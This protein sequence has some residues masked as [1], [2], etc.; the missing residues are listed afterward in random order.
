M[1]TIKDVARDAGVSVGTVSNVLNGGRVSEARRK[2]VEASIEKLGYQ[3]NTL[4]KG[5]RMQK[6]D[7]VVVI[8]PNLI[9]PYF[10]LLLD[11]LES[12][13]SA[14]G[15]QVLL[16]LSGDDAEREVAFMDMAKQNKVDGII[17][18]TYSKVEEERIEN[19]AFVSID[20]HYKSHIPCVAGDNWQG[21]W[22]A[23]ENLHKRGSTN[24][25]CFMTM[26]SVDSEVRKRRVG[27]TEYCME[28]DLSC[29]SVEMSEKQIVSVYES[30]GSR[31]LI[32]NM[33]RAYISPSMGEHSMGEHSI[34]GIF[35][36]S[37]HLA[38]IVREELEE[39]G[40]RV[41]EDIQIIGY[42]GLQFLN[43]GKPIVSSIAQPLHEIA[44]QA[45]KSLTD[46]IE[47]G[48]AEDV[49]NIPVTFHEGS[50]T[51]PLETISE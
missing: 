1:V 9:N 10:A 28:H 27:F 16:C 50:T 7:Y 48:K 44:K 5:M 51:K 6:T 38:T 30:Y 21:G 49:T 12:E 35:T 11:A 47:N 32:H 13:L 37:D 17:G 25:L 39:M 31:K 46:M 43:Q 26:S 45:V 3:V 22:L 42:D 18:V 41:P 34:D 36:S 15:K 20:R 2:L 8:L 4:A 14:V 40:K 19:M 23:A 29:N 24:L 33:L